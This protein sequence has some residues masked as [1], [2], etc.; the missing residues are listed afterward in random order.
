MYKNRNYDCTNYE[1]RE[2]Y[3][4]MFWQQPCDI[5]NYVCAQSVKQ[6]TNKYWKLIQPI[7]T[8]LANISK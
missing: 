6:Q 5:S 7:N 3:K 8:I 1:L 2:V 4:Q